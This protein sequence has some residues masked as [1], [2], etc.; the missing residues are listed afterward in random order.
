MARYRSRRR[1]TGR[2]D[3]RRLLLALSIHTMKKACP[4]ELNIVLRGLS[5]GC[6]S[7]VAT[8]LIL[9]NNRKAVESLK[10][11]MRLSTRPDISIDT[12]N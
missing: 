7:Q 4:A 9:G 11:N 3:G 5:G 8:G 2:N 10:G 6:V 1:V 12:S